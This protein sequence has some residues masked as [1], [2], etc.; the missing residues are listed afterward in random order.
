MA[1]KIYN[2]E[3]TLGEPTLSVFEFIAGVNSTLGRH[4]G[5]IEGEVTSIKKDHPTTVFY[6]IKDLQHEA[7]CECLIWQ[8]TYKTNGIN[9]QVG[10]KVIVTGVPE[11]F[12]RT[13]KF[14]LKTQTIEYA[15]E[16]ALKK[17]YDE[18]KL[19]LL[20]EGL[21]DAGRKRTLPDYPKRIGVIT[22]RSGVVIQDFNS[23]LG[24]YGFLTTMVDCRVEGKDAIHEILAALQTMAK[25]DI[26]VLVIIRGGGSRE[27]LQ[28]FNTESVVRAVAGFKCPVLTGIG[29]DVDVTLAELVADVGASTP[30]GVA[31]VLNETWDTL[32]SSLGI[33][34]GRIMN[35]YQRRLM[36]TARH[37]ES[38]SGWILRTYE[39]VL[40]VTT[41]RLAETTR[42]TQAFYREIE[43]TITIANTTFQLLVGTMK[44][45]MRALSTHL[46]RVE[47]FLLKQLLASIASTNRGLMSEASKV[48]TQQRRLLKNANQSLTNLEH[49]IKLSDPARTL[50]LGYSLSYVQGKV[51]RSVVDVAV[52]QTVETRL[53]DGSFISEVK[54]VL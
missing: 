47:T 51:L 44:T 37:L 42:S 38:R 17:S 40:R 45:Q 6:T 8:S 3:E 24:R 15:G 31:E 41:K 23:N 35:S 34:E 2:F 7:V 28:A 5:R 32:T 36:A 50:K 26:E 27:S 48:A 46:E 25:Q 1:G 43:K 4:R 18:L 21:F 54:Q 33:A 16:G 19:K 12:P 9:V 22:S 29:H 13:G 14:S 53:A 30:T 52:R 49:Q 20:K 11:I 10:D 39:Q